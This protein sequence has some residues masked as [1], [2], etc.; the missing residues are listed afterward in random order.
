MVNYNSDDSPIEHNAFRDLPLL[1]PIQS[2][3]KR[4]MLR[5][6]VEDEAK[7]KFVEQMKSPAEERIETVKFMETTSG[8]RR[9]RE[10]TGT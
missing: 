10:M 2:S 1:G 6:G 4:W 8:V 9:T 5:E 3:E 7:K